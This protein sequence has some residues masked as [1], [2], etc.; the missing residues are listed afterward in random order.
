M[1]GC[2]CGAR[3]AGSKGLGRR[4]CILEATGG[5]MGATYMARLF[6]FLGRGIVSVSCVN[7]DRNCVRPYADDSPVGAG[8]GWIPVEP[9][10]VPQ[11]CNGT[12]SKAPK[13]MVC[14]RPTDQSSRLA[15]LF[16]WPACCL[17]STRL[18]SC[19][20]GR[21]PGKGVPGKGAV[22][23]RNNGDTTVPHTPSLLV[24]VRVHGC[25]WGVRGCE[26]AWQGKQ[27]ADVVESQGTKCTQPRRRREDVAPR[28]R[29]PGPPWVRWDRVRGRLA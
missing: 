22:P 2:W 7:G 19:A 28:R 3:Q 8:T 16:L 21:K 23:L 20:E 15:D 25:P 5:L 10:A 13:V 11:R 24:S 12:T 18:R 14:V 17:A 1:A 27:V 6:A 4:L 29:L 26:G 9:S